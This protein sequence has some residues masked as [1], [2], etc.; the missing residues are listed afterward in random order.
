MRYGFARAAIAALAAAALLIGRAGAAETVDVGIGG[1]ASDAPLYIAQEK[2][3]FNDEGLEVHLIVLDTGA[4][5][6]APLATGELQVGSG[7]L[8]VGFY[9]ALERG[10]GIRIVADRGHTEPG[11]FYQSVFI[12]KDLIDSGAFKTL[13]DLK[14]KQIGFAAPG[15]TALSLLNEA[16]R[17][18]GIAFGDVN[19]VFMSFPQM[20][21]AL[22]NKA[23]DGAILI[24]PQ[25]TML[26][27]SGAGV[28]FMNTEEIYSNDQITV[29]FYSDKFATERPA[30]AQKFMQAFLRAVRF[31]NDALRGGKIAGP[32]ADEIVA[33]MGKAFH[34]GPDIIRDMNSQAVSPDGEV[35]V[36]SIQKDLDFFRSQGWVKTPIK[37]SEIVDMSFAQKASA[38]LGPYRRPSP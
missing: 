21:V 9:N 24:E 14:G 37:L 29:L 30:A 6:I 25:A 13:A 31:Y 38:A 27:H 5:I 10:V 16:T 35:I 17:K 19:P 8:S 2:G 22:T 23:I 11:Y 12:R 33:I 18:A 32:G 1:S 15:V 36:A 28:R 34:L 7:A 3:Y 4:K 20:A 26:V